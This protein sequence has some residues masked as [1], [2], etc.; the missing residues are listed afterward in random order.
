MALGYPRRVMVEFSFLLAIPT[1]GA[2]TVYELYKSRGHLTFEHG[3]LLVL[4][5][6]V[7]F[8]V[9]IL[10]IRF[11]LRF[12]QTHSFAAFGV[13]RLLI[14]GLFAALLIGGVLY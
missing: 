4:G 12:V 1:M 14:A 7:S 5:L 8:V 13:Y 2:A 3:Y 11:L 9:A 6:A 10:A